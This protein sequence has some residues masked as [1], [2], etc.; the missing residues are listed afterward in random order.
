MARSKVSRNPPKARARQQP[1]PSSD[2]A[3]CS[4]RRKS[5][6]KNPAAAAE[7]AKPG[8]HRRESSGQ[9]D[10]AA[11]PA[12]AAAG[13]NPASPVQE[14]SLQVAQKIKEMVLLAQE[15][16]YLTYNDIT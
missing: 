2:S 15:K 9:T 14:T 16:V 8:Q 10:F 5:S 12:A 1:L 7:T 4:A 13:A 11:A 3:G 6:G